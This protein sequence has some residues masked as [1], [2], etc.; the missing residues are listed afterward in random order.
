MSAKMAARR[1]VNA[2][3]AGRSK[4]ILGLPA[5]LAVL[6]KAVSPEA[7][8][9]LMAGTNEW[10]LPAPSEDHGSAKGFESE[11]AL[12]ENALTQLTREAEVRN[13][14]RSGVSDPGPA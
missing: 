1:V 13:N 8:S 12:T 7:L 3:A 10:V 2:C 14:E 6:L 4:V 5:Q 11:S 9:Y